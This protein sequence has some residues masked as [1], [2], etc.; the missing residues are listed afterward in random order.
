MH[1]EH[2]Y[3]WIYHN[4]LFTKWKQE[5]ANDVIYYDLNN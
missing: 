5:T 4:D 3:K 2:I 1:N